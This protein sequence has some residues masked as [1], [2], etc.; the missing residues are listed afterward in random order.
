MKITNIKN[1]NALTFKWTTCVGHL[2]CLVE[3]YPCLVQDGRINE[4]N[5]ERTMDNSFQPRHV[6]PIHSTIIYRYYKN[7]PSCVDI[8][9]AKILW[10]SHQLW[11]RHASTLAHTIILFHIAIIMNQLQLQKNWWGWK[12]KKSNNDHFGYS[13]GC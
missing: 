10:T 12:W 3:N 9:N 6:P 1:Y 2:C 5:W 13:F 8:C 11:P 7:P 4:V